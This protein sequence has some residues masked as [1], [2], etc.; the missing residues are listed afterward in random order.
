MAVVN[1]DM[2]K[3]ESAIR[4]LNEA[5][6]GLKGIVRD[7]DSYTSTIDSVWTKVGAKEFKTALEKDYHE[8]LTKYS[9]ELKKY[10]DALNNAKSKYRTLDSTYSTRSIG[11]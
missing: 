2:S 8:I 10:S 5:S 11:V 6:E 3:L 7:L 1:I 9:E 4:A